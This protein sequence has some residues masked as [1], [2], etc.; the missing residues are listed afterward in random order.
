MGQIGYSSGFAFESSFGPGNHEL[1]IPWVAGGFAHFWRDRS[2]WDTLHFQGPVIYGS[3]QLTSLAVHEGDY[4]SGD[5]DPHRNFEMLVVENGRVAHWFRSNVTPFPWTRSGYLPGIADAV[6]C[7]LCR[8]HERKDLNGNP[9]H[10]I[11]YAIVAL[12]SGGLVGVIRDETLA[13][14]ELFSWKESPDT[15]NWAPIAGNFQ[16]VGWALG[17]V[18]TLYVDFDDARG[19]GDSLLVATTDAGLGQTHD[20]RGNRYAAEPDGDAWAVS[21]AVGEGLSGRPSAIQSDRGRRKPIIGPN[22]QGNYEFVVPRAGGGFH[23]F[24]S[25]NNRFDSSGFFQRV[26]NDGGVIGVEKYDEICV[27]QSGDQDIAQYNTPPLQVFA[28][29]RHQTWVHQFWQLDTD[30]GVE[31]RGPLTIGNRY[32]GPSLKTAMKSK[33]LDPRLGLRWIRPTVDSVRAFIGLNT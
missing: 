2:T 12:R 33:G 22:K 20:E 13:W 14:G 23:H 16:G 17:T 28:W 15:V 26:W 18:G 9:V 31:W 10:N 8:T 1:F 19:S 30:A 5:N 32:A 4:S 24:W 25:D 3:G 7:A 21:K 11:L 29:R 27:F 6:A